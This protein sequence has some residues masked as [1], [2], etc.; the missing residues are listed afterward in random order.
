M[1]CEHLSLHLLS[2]DGLTD[3]SAFGDC[4]QFD[5]CDGCISGDPALNL[6][7]CVWQSC[8]D[9]KRTHV[10][11]EFKCILLCNVSV[12]YAHK[13]RGS[14][15]RTC[16]PSQGELS[17]EQPGELFK[18]RPLQLP[19]TQTSVSVNNSTPLSTLLEISVRET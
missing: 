15:W 10:A 1:L 8:N 2:L 9:G 16:D 11:Y 4:S 5:S 13:Y 14:H 19:S 12:V 7:Q 6:T 18:R 3:D 17:Q